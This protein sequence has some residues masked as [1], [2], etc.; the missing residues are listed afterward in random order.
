MIAQGGADQHDVLSF[1]DEVEFGEVR[2]CETPGC[3][4]KGKL[5]RVQVSGMRAFLMRQ[6]SAFY[7]RL[8]HSARSRRVSTL[9]KDWPWVSAS[10]AISSKRSAMLCRR[11]LLSSLGL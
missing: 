11:R 2:I 9:A 6:A 4:L 5:S 1:A 7:W 10:P 8:C 3:C